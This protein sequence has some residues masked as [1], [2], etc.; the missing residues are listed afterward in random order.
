MIELESLGIMV[1]SPGQDDVSATFEMKRLED[2][3][4][5]RRFHDDTAVVRTAQAQRQGNARVTA[6]ATL[7][8]REDAVHTQ[9]FTSVA[10]TTSHW[11]A[12][13]QKALLCYE[14]S[15]GKCAAWASVQKV[16]WDGAQTAAPGTP[17]LA[18]RTSA[19]NK[20]ADGRT[21][22]LPPTD[23]T[24]KALGEDT[25]CP[26]TDDTTPRQVVAKRNTQGMLPTLGDTASSPELTPAATFTA[27]SSSSP[28][29]TTYVGVV[30]SNMG[31][32]A[33]A[34]PLV[35]APSP[36]SSAEPQPSAANGHFGM[37]RRRAC[38]RCRNG[39]HHHPCAPSPL[40]EV[41]PPPPTIPT[42]EGGLTSC[43]VNNQQTVRRC[44]R[45]RRR[46]GRRHQP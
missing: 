4:T 22:D 41:L 34:T 11:V 18:E 45:P 39:R 35:V 23:M 6:L 1:H 40:D 46:H 30:L 25:K 20:E 27:M 10:A 2:V 36:Q 16:Q 24:A 14:R 13:T 8:C 29:P 31:E 12:A 38:P 21:R 26:V 5:M 32:R 15:W 37:V 43:A 19:N 33:H 3:A 44:H 42:L 7:R 9:A 17:A 28:W